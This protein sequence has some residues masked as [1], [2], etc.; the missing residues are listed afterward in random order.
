[1]GRSS[2]GAMLG[3]RDLPRTAAMILSGGAQKMTIKYPFLT[4]IVQVRKYA[5]PDVTVIS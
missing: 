2:F 1:M 4:C 3:M 5:L